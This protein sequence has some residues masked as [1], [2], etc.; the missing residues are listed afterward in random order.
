[1]AG[2]AFGGTF[3]GH[4][5]LNGLIKRISVQAESSED[6]GERADIF[7][8]AMVTG[9]HRANE[10]WQAHVQRPTE[11]GRTPLEHRPFLV[12]IFFCDQNLRAGSFFW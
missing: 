1:M 5:Q 9:A 3:Q 8:G 11:A 6:A 10:C 7:P 12:A 4:L 2:S